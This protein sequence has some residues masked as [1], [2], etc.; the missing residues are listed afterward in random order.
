LLPIVMFWPFAPITMAGEEPNV[1][2]VAAAV[3]V[4]VEPVP[5][6]IA[7]ETVMPPPTSP[8]TTTAEPPCSSWPLPSWSKMET[9]V[10]AVVD[11]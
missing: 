8:P 4:A 9:T 3:V 5:V 6:V 1:E 11:R 10:G 7:A 2:T